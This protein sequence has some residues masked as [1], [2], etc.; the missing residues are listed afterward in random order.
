MRFIK[1]IPRLLVAITF[2]FSGFVKLVDPLGTSY[3]LTEYFTEDVLDLPFLIPYALPIAIFLILFE[4]VLGVML[5]VGY[6]PKVT[7]WSLVGIMLLFLFLTWYSA[8]FDKV[9]DCGCF[10]DALKMSPWKTFYKNAVLFLLVIYLV[11]QIKNIHPFININVTK[12]VVFIS[13]TIFL[14]II[15]YVFMHLPLIDFRPYAV[16][17]NLPEQM[18]FKGQELPPVHDFYFE[19]TEGVD[20][21]N[22]ILK[23]NKV[24]LIVMYDLDKSDKDGLVGLNDVISS[25]SQNSYMVYA[26]TSS[27]AEAFENIKAKYNL[28]IV[29]L[30]GD[31]ITLK[32]IIRANPGIVILKNG[33]V[34]GKWNWTDI[35]KINF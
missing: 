32:T 29:S 31:E 23:G 5:L 14:Y 13:F 24:L 6:L 11:F 12:W 19:N 34:T 21:T 35:E 26:L 15:Y 4:I 17:K 8:Y 20:F 9:T 1:Q 2:L 22:A 25:A 3:K 10:G 18:Q 16:G 33:T 27:A 30:F 7:T 28:N